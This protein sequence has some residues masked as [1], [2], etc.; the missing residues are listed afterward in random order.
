MSIV[1]V[2]TVGTLGGLLGILMMIPLRRA[3]IVQLHGKAGEPGTLLYPEGTA[4]AQVL[5]SG[6]KGGAGGGA[7]FIGFGI[8]FAHKFITEGMNLLSSSVALPLRL[9]QN[10]TDSFSRVAKLSAEMASEL[11]GVGYIIGVR[12]SSIMMA[13]DRAQLPRQ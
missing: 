5:I 3:F 6:D 12:T 9:G 11:L 10:A 7:V 1:R 2:M 13:G 8:A 4:C